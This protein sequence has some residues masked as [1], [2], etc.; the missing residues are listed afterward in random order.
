MS[1]AA[2]ISIGLPVYNGVRYLRSAIEAHLAQTFGDFELIISDNASTDETPEICAEYAGR[3]KRV[4]Y[5]RQPVN[6]GV[7]LNHARVFALARGGYF[8]WAAV[9]D[10]PAPELLE[11]AVGI[12]DSEPE[13]VTYVPDTAN[14]DESGAV[15]RYLERTLDLREPSP[16]DRAAAV[17]YR[18]F[19]MVFPQG[20]MRRETLLSTSCRWDYF[21]WDFILLFELALRGKLCQVAGPLLYRRLHKESAAACT[22]KVSEVRKWV[23]PTVRS[24]ILLPHWRWTGERLRAVL[25]SRLSTGEQFRLMARVARHA[26]QDRY[27]MKRD[28]IMAGKL[29]LRRTDEYPF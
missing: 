26:C 18:D 13:I 29:L 14:I 23:D 19:Q 22:R 9:D 21:G 10:L 6:C 17:L 20:L 15:K 16:V 25:G 1:G 12:L 8:R 24:P 5:V 27:L 11:H 28:L 4:R 3:D 2:R 7:N